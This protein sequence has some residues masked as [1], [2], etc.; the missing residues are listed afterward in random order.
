MP[1]DT[2]MVGYSVFSCLHILGSTCWRYEEAECPLLTR[3]YF[4]QLRSQRE[5]F[6][7][8]P[9]SLPLPEGTIPVLLLQRV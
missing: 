4:P 5:G 8:L 9:K 3:S 2:L 6:G 1:H 7:E